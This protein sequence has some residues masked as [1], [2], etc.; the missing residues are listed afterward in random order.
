MFLHPLTCLAGR[1][2]MRAQR[3]ARHGRVHHPNMQVI[4][5]PLAFRC[6]QRLSRWLYQNYTVSL[7]VCSLRPTIYCI[8]DQTGVQCYTSWPALAGK[9]HAALSPAQPLT[10][11]K[12]KILLAVLYA[13]IYVLIH[14]IIF[15][16][17][18]YF[19]NSLYFFKYS[20]TNIF[21]RRSPCTF[22]FY[23]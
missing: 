13:I 22:Y 1:A 11:R 5:M 12:T 23:W 9:G 19:W 3:P 15:W 10:T 8:V 17:Y 16:L 21:H 14:H 6:R 4:V 7:P 18:L 20:C 2:R